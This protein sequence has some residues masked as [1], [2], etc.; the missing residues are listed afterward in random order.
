MVDLAQA[1]YEGALWRARRRAPFFAAQSLLLR[2]R[3]R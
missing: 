3:P 1:E 2:E